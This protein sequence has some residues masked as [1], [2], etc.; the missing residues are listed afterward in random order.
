MAMA[1]QGRAR[2]CAGWP[3]KWGAINAKERCKCGQSANLGAL[4]LKIGCYLE[5]LTRLEESVQR[6]RPELWPNKWIIRHN[7]VPAHDVLRVSEVLAKKTI[8]EMGCR[9][10]AP[11][12][13]WL[14]SKLKKLHEGTK[15]WWHSWHP[16]HVTGRYSGK[17]F[18]G[19]GTIVSRST[20][21]Q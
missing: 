14:F 17:R 3:K 16:T 11:C 15:I 20:W 5:V 2:R 18:S 6:K 13:F 1:D 12:S 19:S 21:I 8:K 4:R 10:T 7:I 9:L